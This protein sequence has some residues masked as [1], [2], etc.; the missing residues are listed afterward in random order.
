MLREADRYE[1]GMSRLGHALAGVPGYG[2]EWP[3]KPV[4][5]LIEELASDELDEGFEVEVLNSR[6]VTSRGLEE[7]GAQELELVRKYNENAGK[8]ADR[9]PRVA[10]TLRRIADSYQWDATRNEEEAERFRRGL[11]Y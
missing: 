4:R 6:G 3:P 7:G 1:I 2:E 8:F 10:A 11:G 9:W 5:D